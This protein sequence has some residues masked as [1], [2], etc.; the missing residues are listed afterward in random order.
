MIAILLCTILFVTSSTTK[1]GACSEEYW[2]PRV[3]Y[4]L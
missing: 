2:N 3:M 4:L 1:Q